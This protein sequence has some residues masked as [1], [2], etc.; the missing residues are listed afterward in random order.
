M[1]SRKYNRTQFNYDSKKERSFT[2]PSHL[3]SEFGLEFIHKVEGI[4]INED[5]QFGRQGVIVTADYRINAPI[6]LTGQLHEITRDDESVQ[7]VNDGKVGFKFEAYENEHGI[8]YTVK[9]VDL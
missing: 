8:Q 9:W 2:K 5:T 1:F 6:H 7:L 3:V 4:Y